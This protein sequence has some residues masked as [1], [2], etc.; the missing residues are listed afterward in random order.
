M[1]ANPLT[2]AGGVAA[3][4]ATPAS[5]AES[6]ETRVLGAVARQPLQRPSPLH[7]RFHS[8]R[9]LAGGSSLFP[10]QILQTFPLAASPGL[11]PAPGSE[12]P[13]RKV[14][15]A[16][17]WE[18]HPHPARAPLT[19]HSPTPN[20]S[21]PLSAPNFLTLRAP[22]AGPRLAAPQ[23]PPHAELKPDDP[24]QR[25]RIRRLRRK[26]SGKSPPGGV[27]GAPR[28]FPARGDSLSPG[29]P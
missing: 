10:N 12:A 17:R 14:P 8:P 25:P 22:R 7:R 18:M 24:Q 13:S 5:S 29:A 3:H 6:P 28:R 27:W 21:P 16:P 2:K 11:T 23:H 19:F 9:T 20:R 15:S 26:A 1:F 4:L